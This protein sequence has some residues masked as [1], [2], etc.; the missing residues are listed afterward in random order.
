MYAFLFIAQLMRRW[1]RIAW[2]ASMLCCSSVV[3]VLYCTSSML[4]TVLPTSCVL[5]DITTVYCSKCF[6]LPLDS[7]ICLGFQKECSNWY[8]SYVDVPVCDNLSVADDFRYNY[9]ACKRKQLVSSHFQHEHTP[10]HFQIL[11]W[12][13]T[14]MGILLYKIWNY[15]FFCFWIL[16]Y[17]IAAFSKYPYF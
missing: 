6:T 14:Y 7:S 4:G 12:V 11:L 9:C 1:L 13:H 10:K 8:M 15:N 3:L 17:R 16:F 5:C 2:N